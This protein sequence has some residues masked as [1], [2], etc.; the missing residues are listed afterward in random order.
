MKFKKVEISAFR[1]FDKVED[2]TFDFTTEKGD[3][4]NFVSLYAPNGF[5]KTSFYDAVEWGVTNSISRFLIKKEE[6]K[7]LADTQLN[8]NDL[9][10][11]RNF[12]SN[13]DPFVKISFDNPH[14][15]IFRKIGTGHNQKYDF[16]FKDSINIEQKEFQKV[17][18]SQEWISSFLLEIEG[19]DRYKKFIEIPELKN[20][21]QYFKDIKGLIK[22]N[23]NKIIALKAK[24]EEIRSQ[25][26]NISEEK[27]LTNVNSCIESL[28]KKGEKL[29]LINLLTT[30]KET[31][32]FKDLIASKTLNLENEIRSVNKY[33]ESIF[34]AKT[35]NGKFIGINNYITY[36]KRIKEFK[37]ELNNI[38]NLIK[39]IDVRNKLKENID[40]DITQRRFYY[41]QKNLALNKL[42]QYPDYESI[43][44]ATKNKK[45]E[46]DKAE[47][48]LKNI[49]ILIAK[50]RIKAT[51]SKTKHEAL[52]AQVN[53]IENNI[54]NIASLKKDYEILS[55]NIKMTNKLLKE[56][57]AKKIIIE[58]NTK[59]CEDNISDIKNTIAE[60]RNGH[61]PIRSIFGTN[62]EILLIKELKSNNS[63]IKTVTAKLKEQNLVI[64]KNK[65]LNS[66]VEEFVRK[67]LEIAR[68]KHT[69]NCPLCNY[70]YS[71]YENLVSKISN[72]NLIGNK[73][74]E[75]LK[76]NTKTKNYYSSLEE[77]TK[78]KQNKLIGIY[79]KAL[80]KP[81]MELETFRREY[82]KIKRKIT[83][84]QNIKDSSTDKI[85]NI[86]QI[87]G[88]VSFIMYEK[89]MKKVHR[90]LKKNIRKS[91]LMYKNDNNKLL[92]FSEE[93]INCKKQ[94]RYLEKDIKSLFSNVKY[95]QIIEWFS[96]YSQN[97]KISKNVISN[98]IISITK[99]IDILTLKIKNNEIK[100]DDLTKVIGPSSKKDV[101]K[102]TAEITNKIDTMTK[103][104]D[105]YREY[106]KNNLNISLIKGSQD[107][108]NKIFKIKEED[109]KIKSIKLSQLYEEYK[110]LSKYNDNLLPYLLSANAK[111]ELETIVKEIKYLEITMHPFLETEKH[112]IKE[113]LENK[114][115]GFFYTD[116]INKIYNKIDPH[117]IFLSVEFKVN[118]DNDN[119]RLDIIVK[120]PTQK[121]KIIPN[122]YFST[123]QINIL[124]LSIFMASALNS[125]NYD[126]IFIDDPIQSMDSINVLSTIDLFR[127]LVINENKQII[128]STHDENF[129]NLLMKKIPQDIFKSK[130][131]EFE[132]LGKIKSDTNIAKEI[133]RRNIKKQKIRN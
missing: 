106:L 25:I 83:E 115:K 121:Q 61:Y 45:K 8:E 90:A 17:I 49:D 101:E 50:Y 38:N 52:N 99:K 21:D 46:L 11:L 26:L 12:T 16:Q 68:V 66:I 53:E 89:S 4:A 64:E 30:Q 92:S 84:Y 96:D 97:N 79:E 57:E 117:P 13:R 5:G 120:D 130:Y 47:K 95:L 42:T 98:Y 56:V 34:V 55:M 105:H 129:H 48:L 73:Y 31:L 40:R 124:S 44:V 78:E 29:N 114:I 62:D 85:G 125:K 122:L 19:E 20:L 1:I 59:K 102:K 118:L 23:N 104:I 27:F 113:Y 126:S 36:L 116:L 43:V 110:K 24:T 35:G 2:S 58:A 18:L 71:S 133:P 75:L 87:T 119:P 70:N 72:N 81:Q 9:P 65:S 14:K 63:E 54:N 132:T 41:Q 112:K 128:L 22:A 82:E 103:S 127:S 67:G 88:G 123:A 109:Y 131:I 93:Q 60:T 100:I 74:L 108:I 10:I 6:N 94:I 33:I 107:K 37:K 77:I 28:N 91:L 15:S 86:K 51:E 7:D 76:E 69:S 111:I 32:N 80:L 39:N 3:I